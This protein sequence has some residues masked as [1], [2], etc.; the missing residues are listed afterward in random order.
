[1]AA[2]LKQRIDDD[3]KA[4]LLSGDRFAAQTLRGLKAAVLNEEVALGRREDGLN[5]EEVEKIIAK[6]VKKRNESIALYEQ[7]ARPELADDEKKESDILSVYLPQ[8]LSEDELKE[9]ITAKVAE[10]GASS[11]QAMGQVIGAVKA[12][13]GNTADG[14]TVARLVK[15]ALN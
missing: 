9:I 3:L 11:P 14:A 13:V 4:A 2:A 10:L 7:N 6:E 12:Q 1:M 15:E 8:Q 5:D